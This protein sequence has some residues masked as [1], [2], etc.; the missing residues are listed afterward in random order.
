MLAASLSR[1]KTLQSSW[2]CC[3]S[4]PTAC[5]TG[6]PRSRTSSVQTGSATSS[7]YTSSQHAATPPRCV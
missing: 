5:K 3:R 1:M 4:P 2:L 6:S 7:F